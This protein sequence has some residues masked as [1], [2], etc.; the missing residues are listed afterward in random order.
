[1]AHPYNVYG[2]LQ[3]NGSWR[4]PSQ[5]YRSEGILNED[6]NKWGGGDGFLS[7]VDT[8]NNRILYSESQYLGLIRWDLE[9]GASRNIR[10]NQPE[11]F[12]G[13]RRNWTTWPDLDDPYMELGNAM[14]PGN[15]DGPSSS[16]HTIPTLCM[17][18]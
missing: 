15:W 9:T 10:P 6:W 12:I 13:A 16:A 7:L 17:P 1:M 14:P 8:T 5:T 2:G 3:D 18:D 11:G 4:G